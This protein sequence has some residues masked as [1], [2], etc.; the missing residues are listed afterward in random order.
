MELKR[1]KGTLGYYKS[2]LNSLRGNIL[3]LLGIYIVAIMLVA[4]IEVVLEPMFGEYVEFV[5]R[6]AKML[7][8]YGLAAYLLKLIRTKEEAAFN[9]ILSFKDNIAT[10]IGAG[11]RTAIYKLPVEIILMVTLSI[12]YLFI[13]SFK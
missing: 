11:V 3:K 5:R 9:E 1:E 10:S 6:I 4:A 7:L 12:L 2:A 8:S 13:D